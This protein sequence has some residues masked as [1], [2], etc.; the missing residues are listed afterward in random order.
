MAKPYWEEEQPVEVVSARNKLRWFRKAA[1]LHVAL[2][3]W[4]TDSGETRPGKTVA[5]NVDALR[6]SED[7]EKA[8]EIFEEI[9]KILSTP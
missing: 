1:R 8:R 6:E 4:Q 3:D 9:V 7:A 2:P 5:L